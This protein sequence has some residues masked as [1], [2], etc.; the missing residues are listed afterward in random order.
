M[1]VEPSLQ[2][3]QAVR[4]CDLEPGAPFSL[5]ARE[6][7]TVESLFYGLV[8]HEAYHAGQLGLTR[9]LLGLEAAIR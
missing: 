8:F 3:N 2:G 7:E 9:R 4:R 6:H 1:T 5:G